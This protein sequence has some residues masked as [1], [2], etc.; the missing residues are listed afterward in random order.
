MTYAFPE[1][2]QVKHLGRE[3]GTAVRHSTKYSNLCMYFPNTLNLKA[4]DNK[5]HTYV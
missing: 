1:V 5:V 4:S 3:V 2:Q